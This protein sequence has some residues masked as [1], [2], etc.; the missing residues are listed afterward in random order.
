MTVMLKSDCEKTNDEV[1]QNDHPLRQDTEKSKGFI[2]TSVRGVCIPTLPSNIDK[3]QLYR[4]FRCLNI[5]FIKNIVVVKKARSHTAFITV[6]KWF[7]NDKAR[8]ILD[9]LEKDNPV[10][11]CNHFPEYLKCY[12]LKKKKEGI[13]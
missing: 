3:N 13:I 7:N 2:Q 12:V 11:I 9:F 8:H 1:G 6:S 5:G 4:R 10:Y